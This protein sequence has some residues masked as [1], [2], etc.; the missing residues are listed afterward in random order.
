MSSAGRVVIVGAGLG[1]VRTAQ[2]LRARG[3]TAMIVLVGAE[4]HPPYDRVPLSKTLLI[5]A[6]L[7]LT[8]T[9]LLTPEETERLQVEMIAGDA[10]IALDTAERSVTLRSGRRLCYDSLVIA[11]GADER[12]LP[13]LSPELPGVRYLRTVE[14]A[15][16]LRTELSAARHVLVVGGGFIGCE[17]ASAA[18]ALGRRATILTPEDTLMTPLGVPAARHLTDLHRGRGV[19]VFTGAMVTHASRSPDGGIELEFGGSTTISGDLAVVGVGAVPA[20]GWL[21]GSGIALDGGVVV[22]REGRTSVPGVFAVGDVTHRFS[23]LHGRHLPTGHWQAAADQAGHVA[24]QIVEAAGGHTER[25]PYFWSDQLGLRIQVVGDPLL[26]D[27]SDVVADRDGAKAG[28]AVLYGRGDSLVGGVAV[29]HPHAF[30]GM[31]RAFATHRRFADA[32]AALT[33][34]APAS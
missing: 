33:T 22:D 8:R 10:A 24:D 26:A 13:G 9:H 2:A 21:A 25:V 28:Y 30:L 17:V 23:E 19:E 4:T 18:L 31:R 27:H 14:H 11:T 5:D 16:L 34:P 3:S 15:L 7:D 1:G 20:V 6:E 32:A 12:L 29:G